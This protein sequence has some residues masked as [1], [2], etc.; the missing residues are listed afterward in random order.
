PSCRKG[1]RTDL[2]F[3]DEVF[4]HRVC[5][6]GV[7]TLRDLAFGR[8]LNLRRDDVL[9]PVTF[10]RRHITRKFEILQTGESDVVGTADAGFQHAAAPHGDTVIAADI[11]NGA[12]FFVTADAAELD[13]DDPASADLDRLTGVLAGMN[14]FIKTDWRLDVFLQ[15]CMV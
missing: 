13:V 6:S 12:N 2:Q 3:V 15:L 1:L 14:R 9:R 4:L 8:Y 5:D 11:V 10:A 7:V